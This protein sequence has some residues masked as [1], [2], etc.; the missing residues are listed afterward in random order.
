MA[1]LIMSEGEL[2]RAEIL[3]DLDEERLTFEAAEQL[4]GLGRRQVFRVLRAYKSE[5]AK[6]LISRKRGRPSN[7]KSPRFQG[8]A[9][10]MDAGG[11]PLA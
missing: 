8:D 3:R 5:G 10:E 1:V 4:L 9:A 2:A 11:R 6:G 7:R